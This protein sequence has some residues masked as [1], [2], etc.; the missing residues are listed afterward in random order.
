MSAGKGRLRDFT[1]CCCTEGEDKCE[2]AVLA[3]ERDSHRISRIEG[4]LSMQRS[5]A[6]RRALRHKW[7]AASLTLLGDCV[8]GGS[9]LCWEVGERVSA[10]MVYRSCPIASNPRSGCFL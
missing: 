8:L 2:S 10:V 7:T 6:G 9:D 4:P 5:L 1:R 3:S